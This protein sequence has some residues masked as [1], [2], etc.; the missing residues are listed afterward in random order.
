MSEDPHFTV[1]LSSSFIS[2]PARPAWSAW[3]PIAMSS[4]SSMS[5]MWPGQR[6]PGEFMAPLERLEKDCERW[7][8][9][10]DV[11]L[12]AM[13]S[14]LVATRVTPLTLYSFWNKAW[15]LLSEENSWEISVSAAQLLDPTPSL[16]RI[17]EPCWRSNFRSPWVHF[18]THWKS[19][20]MKF[21]GRKNCFYVLICV[22]KQA[23]KQTNK[24]LELP[25]GFCSLQNVSRSLYVNKYNYIYIYTYT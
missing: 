21:Q 8:R 7:R 20:W 13:F 10:H 9:W 2:L 6:A 15:G 5:S 3:S 17:Q 16:R 24:H 4:M 25:L 11:K 18:A 22:K 19:F 12:M 23:N 1:E 14:P